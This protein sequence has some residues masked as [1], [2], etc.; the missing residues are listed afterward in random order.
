ME[1]DQWIANQQELSALLEK[2]GISQKQAVE[3]IN[4]QP[5]NPNIKIRTLRSWLSKP[6]AI[7]SR[8]CPDWAAKS[9]K[10]AIEAALQIKS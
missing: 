3:M 6:T 2:H 8:P 7:S 10:T 1:L 4:G 9:L 5:N